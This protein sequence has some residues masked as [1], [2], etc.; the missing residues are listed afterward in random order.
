MTQLIPYLSF[1]GNCE[2]AFN[3]YKECLN[4][5]IIRLQRYED[6][7]MQVAEDYKKRILHLAF[8]F[9]DCEI[10]A[11][12]SIQGFNVVGNNI[13]LSINIDNLERAEKYFNNLAQ[14]GK[15]IMPFG[16]TFWG[17]KFGMIIDKF[18]INWMINCEI[19]K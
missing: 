14:D 10:M 11:A 12:D 6:S 17:A 4:G 9:E 19:K 13:S 18:S 2:A 3:F 7:P 8:K 1:D 5:E 16:D 15:I